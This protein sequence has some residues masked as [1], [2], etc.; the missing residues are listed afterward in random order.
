MNGKSIDISGWGA[1][2]RSVR[3]RLTNDCY[4]FALLVGTAIGPDGS[5]EVVIFGKNRVS[6]WQMWSKYGDKI[7]Q[8]EFV[9]PDPDV[10]QLLDILTG[11]VKPG[12]P[13]PDS[14]PELE[15]GFGAE[16]PF[17]DVDPVDDQS[18]RPARKT[19][20]KNSRL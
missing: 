18:A 14:Q 9:N 5:A 4:E 8:W 10:Q 19:A 20:V 2:R 15:K 12:A 7:G 11:K 3:Y 1:S 16:L 6:P 13:L 17:G